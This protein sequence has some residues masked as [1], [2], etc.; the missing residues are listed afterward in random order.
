MH[1]FIHD[2]EEFTLELTVKD[3][4]ITW[5]ELLKYV[6]QYLNGCGFIVSPTVVDISDVSA[7]AHDEALSKK[8]ANVQ[9]RNNW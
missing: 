4:D 3:N 6:Q 7:D 5:V 1:K 8:D 2:D 9:E